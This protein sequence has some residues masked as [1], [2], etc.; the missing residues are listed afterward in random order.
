MPSALCRLSG[1]STVYNSLVKVRLIALRLRR[2]EGSPLTTDWLAVLPVEF[3]I[4]TDSEGASPAG[5]R[6]EHDFAHLSIRIRIARIGRELSMK[7]ADQPSDWLPLLTLMIYFS[8]FD[9][10]LLCFQFFTQICTC[11]WP[12]FAS[13]VF[14][15]NRFDGSLLTSSRAGR[16]K[17]KGKVKNDWANH[18][19]PSEH[20]YMR[21]V[22]LHWWSS[23][24]LKNKTTQRLLKIYLQ[25]F[26][27]TREIT[28]WLF[29]RRQS[30][31]VYSIECEAH[32][33]S[34]T[35]TTVH[36]VANRFPS[37]DPP[38]SRWGRTAICK[39]NEL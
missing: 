17:V 31:C 13:G 32:Y 30:A 26:A 36:R 9:V 1:D 29:A 14:P 7:I 6:N 2:L 11:S 20:V 28:H 12:Q 24:I 19:L 34:S 22:K 3:R 18:Q 38:N 15:G 16:H 21:T 37:M 4:T 39:T 35:C 27:S 33:C 23:G 10:L 25:C 8:N 5:S